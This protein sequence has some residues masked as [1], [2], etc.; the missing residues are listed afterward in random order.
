MTLKPE[1]KNSVMIWLMSIEKTN[2][3]SDQVVLKIR[4]RSLPSRCTRASRLSSTSGSA[5]GTFS[6]SVGGSTG[7]QDGEVSV[8]TASGAVTDVRSC[9]DLGDLCVLFCKALIAHD[10]AARW[11]RRTRCSSS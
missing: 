3:H 8:V 4:G 10:L 11:L 5:V 6:A 1:T 2:A 9:P 7:D